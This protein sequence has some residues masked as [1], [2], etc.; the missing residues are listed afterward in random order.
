VPR[1][2]NHNGHSPA[3][4]SKPPSLPPP[5]GPTSRGRRQGGDA[6]SGRVVD[7]VWRHTGHVDDETLTCTREVVCTLQCP[8]C[9]LGGTPEAGQ[10]AAS[11]GKLPHAQNSP[12]CAR[13]LCRIVLHLP[14]RYSWPKAGRVGTTSTVAAHK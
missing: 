9:D 11:A 2:G 7:R 12:P 6:R 3:T 4:C 14:V 13:A 10:A 5:P 8:P 1:V